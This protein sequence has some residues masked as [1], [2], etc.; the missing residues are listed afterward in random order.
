[1]RVAKCDIESGLLSISLSIRFDLSLSWM[2]TEPSGTE[3]NRSL[4]LVLLASPWE[5]GEEGCDSD[6]GAAEASR[7]ARTIGERRLKT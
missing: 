5:E 7:S 4:F 3:T 2:T 1:M 6:D